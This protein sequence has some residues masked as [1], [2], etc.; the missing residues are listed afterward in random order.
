LPENITLLIA[1]ALVV[2][3]FLNFGWRAFFHKGIYIAGI[4]SVLAFAVTNPFSILDLPGFFY[5]LTLASSAQTSHIGMEGDT[6]RWYASF[7]W[8]S[9]GVLIIL[10]L[11]QAMLILVTR[12]K[13]GLV[14]LSFPVLYYLFI[15]QFNVRN[16]RTVMLV[17]PFMDLLAALCVADLY[18]RVKD[19]WRVS[20]RLSYIGLGIAAAL[21]ALTPLQNSIQ[22]DSDLLR[23]D[24][25]ETARVW[26]E[27]NLPR[28]S[29][30]ALEAY[31]PYVD[32]NHF[33]VEG[34][35]RIIDHS[36]DW[37]AQ[38]GF[39]DLV[40]SYGAYGRY[41]EDSDRFSNFVAR[42]E[43][44][45]SRF[46]EL[47]RFAEGGTQIRIYETNVTALPTQRTAARFGEFGG[48]VELVGYDPLASNWQSGN[49]QRIGL[50]W[51]ALKARRNPLM[52]TVRL[53]DDRDDREIWQS[54][55]PL[56][57][58]AHADGFWPQGITRTE[59]EISVPKNLESG[60]YR[61]QIEIDS[62]G[63]G[64]VPLLSITDQPIADKHFLGPFKISA[65]PPSSAELTSA[66]TVNANFG[67]VI[68][69]V[70]SSTNFSAH[71][72]DSF[73]ATRWQP[74]QN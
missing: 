41:Y 71:P 65:P 8:A 35:E 66:Q 36:P 64:R 18:E 43:A 50:Y 14:L 20:P 47:K 39:E 31:S 48:W 73:A 49:D 51:R 27:E 5:G 34:F 19:A 56:F 30:I 6:V 59:R 17:I 11:V 69:L 62:E 55:A 46:S 1:V 68:T 21:I 57:G 3:H 25:R 72:G 9:E 58:D 37:Y 74:M 26:I 53:I 52:L 60:L 44:F 12:N 61:V 15:N 13:R 38:N 16:D 63:V 29:R 28:G 33:M 40:F 2:A 22:S 24:A 23:S 70:A 45:F 54:R 32:R 4:A 7:L 10:A 67:N 42:Y